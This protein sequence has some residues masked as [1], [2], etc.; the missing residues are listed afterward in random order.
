M[1]SISFFAL[2]TMTAFF[3]LS[4][5][6]EQNDRPGDKAGKFGVVMTADIDEVESRVN[7]A[8][9]VFSWAEGDQV[10]L[11][12]ADAAYPSATGCELLTAVQGGRTARFEGEFS[13]YK[14]QA[15]LYAYYSTDGAFVS[16]TSIAFRKEVHSVQ[17]GTLKSLSEN[18]FFYSWIKKADI[19]L[20]KDG[21]VLSGMNI[22]TK[23]SPFFAILKLNVPSSLGYTSLKVEAQSA[24][25]G[26][27]Q[28]QPQKTWGSLG[29]SGFAYRPTGTGMAQ[30]TSVQISDN[31]NVIGDYVYI[32][33]IP[34]AYDEDAKN[35]C[36]SSSVLKFT[37][38]G[39]AGEVEFE[40]ELNGK[41]YNGTLKD[42]G[43]V[44]GSM[45]PLQ[46]AKLCLL[47][48]EQL[49]VSVAD[50]VAYT[51]YYYET[52]LTESDCK[53]PTMSSPRFYAKNGFEVP[54]YNTCS[55]HFIKV[56]IR[57]TLPYVSETVAKGHLRQWTFGKESPVADAIGRNMTLFPDVS[58]TFEAGGMSIYRGSSNS[59]GV[60]LNDDHMVL[61]TCYVP[62]NAVVQNNAD[63]WL[64]FKVNKNYDRG[65]KLFNDN[66]YYGTSSINGNNVTTSVS[67][68][69]EDP[70]GTKSFV[71]K[72]GAVT[73]G[74]MY[75]VRGDGTH[76]YYSMAFLETGDNVES[77][78]KQSIKVALK[79]QDCCD[80]P[81]VVLDSA[82][83]SDSI[84]NGAEYYFITGTEGFDALAD[85]TPSDAR[86]TSSGIAIPVQN[87]SDRLYI[88]VL[89]RCD[90]CE[91]V[92]IK[93]I[94]RNWKFDINYIAPQTLETEYDGLALTLTANYNETMCSD[95]RIGYIGI[96]KGNAVIRPELNGS[97]WLNANFFGGSFGTTFKILYGTEKLYQ[98]DMPAKVYYSDND[99]MKSVR[100]DDLSKDI[101]PICEWSYN[102]WLRNIIF[103]EQA[104]YM[105]AQ[106][107]G[108]V[109]IEDFDGNI[110]YN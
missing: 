103:L 12:W 16:K 66:A 27:V 11:R 65:Y 78:V 17:R 29:S 76:A 107:G 1:K 4:C 87:K 97:G 71:W 15:N 56:L 98:I 84:I 100:I 68:D 101:T 99:I 44:P 73:K 3:C 49:K 47:S 38:A 51:E 110:N 52:G 5:V 58:D 9:T 23:I 108:D 48:D 37:L 8:S 74:Q 24:I 67:K 69:I 2:L 50:T 102:I 62:I 10:K 109:S 39:P 79:I 31:G 35:Y 26:H 95:A 42:L 104:M 105:P 33:V 54:D 70:F 72:L 94:L 91:D 61:K 25:A 41:I 96:R 22:T 92:Y 59:L 75:G 43:S 55:S 13:E 64:Y 106:Y 53:T 30:N 34:D 63:A 77:P 6:E 80:V 81:A 28:L 19:E 60:T 82:K 36:C 21:D 14:E 93:A 20:I 7:L 57:K 89:G 45:L 40:K 18:L 46:S 32:V 88:K 85:P 83:V 86:L 90:G